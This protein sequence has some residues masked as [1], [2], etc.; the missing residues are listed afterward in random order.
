MCTY[1]GEKFICEQMESI[2]SQG[3]LPYELVVCDDRSTDSTIALLRSFADRVRFPVKIVS[4]EQRLGP[5]KN[6]EKAI[7]HCG[8]DVIVLSDQDDI[9]RPDK[10][11]KFAHAL[12]RNPDAAYAF[13]N[14]DM[15]DENGVSA[16]RTMWEAVGLQR[17]LMQFSGSNQL[18]LLLKR[19]LIAGASMAFRA[20]FRDVVVPIPSGWLH[21]YWIVLMGSALSR[22]VAIPDRLLIYRRHATQAVGWR[23]RTFGQSVQESIAAGQSVLLAK[24]E[25]FRQIRKRVDSVHPFLQCSAECLDLLTQK[26]NHL[27]N[28]ASMRSAVGLS[29]VAQVLVEACTGRYQRYSDSWFSIARDL[30]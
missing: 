17:K 8:G 21:D 5:A 4:N 14:G 20:S 2:A 26:E 19:N 13:S 1:N 7:L 29:R 22:G 12:D 28:R 3:L 6:F 9:W 30:R 10:L 23:K 16:G 25:Q 24:V 18:R 27:E 11:Q 15:V